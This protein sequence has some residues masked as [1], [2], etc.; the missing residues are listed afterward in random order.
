MKKNLNKTYIIAEI[1]PNH[2]GNYKIAL[3]M[4]NKLSKIGVNAVKFQLSNP[5][6]S[7][8]LDAFKPGYQKKNNKV[9]DIFL[10]SKNRQ[11]SHKE[12][13]K[14][15]DR[16]DKLGLDYLCTPFDLESLIFLDQEINVSMFKIA[17]G[18][19]F[20]LDMIE[21]ISKKKNQFYFQQ[22]WQILE[23]SKKFIKFYLKKK[24]ILQFFIVFLY[25]LRQ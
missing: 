21:Y 25:I 6:K 24:E 4:I 14:L 23:R 15:K 3:K 9:D 18:E 11:L 22:A 2:N 17:S 10:S 19:I 1:G 13:K 20:S 8:S 12:H 7:L 5:D 16:C